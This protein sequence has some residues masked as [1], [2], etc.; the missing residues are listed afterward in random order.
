MAPWVKSYFVSTSK[1]SKI[2]PSSEKITFLGPLSQKLFNFWWFG[3]FSAVF[4]LILEGKY[5]NFSIPIPKFYLFQLYTVHSADHCDAN[6]FQQRNN[7]Q[8]VLIARSPLLA[9][10][11]MQFAMPSTPKKSLDTG[12]AR[13]YIEWI[14]P[15]FPQGLHQTFH[16]SH[17]PITDIP[18]SDITSLPT[19]VQQLSDFY[20]L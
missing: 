2:Y 4:G 8:S 7:Q 11:T 14:S 1:A 20:Q 12:T 13:L 5:G 16:R 15:F 10:L 17:S 9:C 19:F 6:R 18:R 3:V